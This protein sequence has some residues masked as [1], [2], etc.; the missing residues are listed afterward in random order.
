MPGLIG[1]KIAMT[2]IFKEDGTVIPVTVLAVGPCPV[3]RVKTLASDGYA[4]V[5][6][7]Y[8]PIAAAKLTRPQRGYLEHNKLEM[9]KVLREL[10]TEGTFEPGA[11][12]DVTIFEAGERVDVIGCSKGRGFQ[13]VVRR[14]HY[15]G[16][17]ET[18]G[19]K[20]HDMPGSIGASAWPS[21]V[22]KGRRLPG[23]MGMVRR[24]A[25]NVQV[26][27]IDPERHLLLI[28]GAIPGGRNSLV[29]VRKRAGSRKEG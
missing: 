2:Q 24:T 28:R 15:K 9:H 3:V 19:C 5:Q 1:K 18:H 22:I 29:L 27:K 10:R 16:G 13:G 7:A 25:K 11:V 12:L 6:L 23:H 20:T 4:A 26:V 8:E 17:P 21:R 14:H